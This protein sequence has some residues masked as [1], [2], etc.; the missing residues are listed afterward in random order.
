MAKGVYFLKDLQVGDSDV[1]PELKLT[2]VSEV[3]SIV[4]T[5]KE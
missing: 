1:H 5:A 3:M 2:I 4:I